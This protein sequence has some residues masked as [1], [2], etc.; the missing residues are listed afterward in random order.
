MIVPSRSPVLTLAIVVGGLWLI[1]RAAKS[2]VGVAIADLFKPDNPKVTPV[3]SPPSFIP[4]PT[5]WRYS[6]KASEVPPA[7]VK[8]ASSFLYASKMGQFDDHGDW[9]LIKEWHFDDHVD[10]VLKWHPG[11]TVL[12]PQTVVA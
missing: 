1:S 9:G 6:R 8:T 4:L 10:G 12:V 3:G 5:G 11:V 2:V 7:A